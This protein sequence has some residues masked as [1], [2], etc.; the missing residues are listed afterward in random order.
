MK[1]F[2]RIFILVI[3]II[4]LIF[5]GVNVYIIINSEQNGRI[6]RVEANRIAQQISEEGLDDISHSEY[7]YITNVEIN[8]GNSNKFFEGGNS[9]YLIKEIN[10]AYYRFD[11]V[12]QAD[13]YINHTILIA[14]LAMGIMALFIIGIMI[15]L[16]YRLLKPF[17]VLKDVPYELSKGNLTVP[18]KESKN[19]FFGRFVWGMDL[20]RE[21]I[22]EQRKKE[23]ALQKEK[24]ILILSISHDIKTPLSAIKLYSKALSKNLYADSEKQNE[25][26]EHINRKADEIEAFVSQIIKASNEDF[27]NLEVTMGEF[28]LSVLLDSIDSYYREKLA[29]LKIDFTINQ[30]TNCLLKG[31][32]NRSIE[33][34]QNIIENA[35]KYG[36]GQSIEINVS[37]EEECRLITVINRGCNISQSELPHIFDSFWRGSNVGNNGGSGLGLYICRQLMM[38]MDGDIFAECKD[39]TMSITSVFQSV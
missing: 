18:L 39:D 11:Y 27:L 31:D 22:E 12:A 9:D 25:I 10:G 20:L 2:N 29:L 37:N 6:Y 4:V 5:A 26:A 33:V 16:R 36:D 23:L 7:K 17:H 8:T 34:L 14:N 3:A 28:Y 32:M 35:V 13:D 30:Y 38:K 15:Y 24:K 1:S 19:R 21:N